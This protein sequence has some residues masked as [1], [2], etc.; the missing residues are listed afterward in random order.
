MFF[1]DTDFDAF[2]LVP[3]GR[4]YAGQEE[5]AYLSRAVKSEG[6][7]DPVAYAKGL[8]FESP[9]ILDRLEFLSKDGVRFRYNRQSDGS[10]KTLI[11][12]Y[13]PTEKQ[14]T[15]IGSRFDSTYI[16]DVTQMPDRSVVTTPKSGLA[17]LDFGAR[18]TWQDLIN[19]G[20][21]GWTAEAGSAS[22]FV[23]YRLGGDGPMTDGHH[24]LMLDG[25]T[26]FSRMI[27]TGGAGT[28]RLSLIH[29]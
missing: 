13:A 9:E 15:P 18:T 20:I 6:P 1:T 2:W 7:G 28:E 27:F 16:L 5:P 19:G 21:S 23:I 26:D 24:R 29:I 3:A 4:T 17:F 14:D 25:R 11:T 10:F 8:E 12:G 22:G